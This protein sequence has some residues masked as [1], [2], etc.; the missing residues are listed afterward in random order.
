[1]GKKIWT[2]REAKEVL[3]TIIEIT[4]EY[5]EKCSV[6]AKELRASIYPE[7][8]ME[9]KEA[10]IADLVQSW[11]GQMLALGLD[12]KGLWL[13]DFDHGKGYYC[14]TWGEDDVM[15]EHG[16]NDGFRS[17]KLIEKPSEDSDDG[18]Q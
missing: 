10:E 1:M 11:S 5:Y 15:Y 9:T 8:V 3:P 2:L 17:R 16:Y 12:V 7:N 6:L 18:N 4:S 13:V 14:W